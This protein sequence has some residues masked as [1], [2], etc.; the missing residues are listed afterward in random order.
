MRAAF[1]VLVVPLLAVGCLH[2]RVHSDSAR[3]ATE[4]LLIAE[5]A[6]RAVGSVD[7]P[8]VSGREVALEVVGLGPGKEFYQDVPYV[9][10]A[11]QHR[12]LE[13]GAT[14]VESGDAELVMMVRVA[15]LGTVARQF[16]LGI[17]YFNVGFYQN[18][19]QHGYAKLRIV[20]RD[21][22]GASVAESEPVME[23]SRHDFLEVMQIIFRSQD[24]YPDQ[25]MVGID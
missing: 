9:Q 20:T 13:E 16:I 18:S 3:T 5:A 6:E 12:L 4:Q 22:A 8:S 2:Q 24:I 15:A 21:G 14:I 25:R 23:R 10:A 7:L 19:K 1:V 17:P 11:L